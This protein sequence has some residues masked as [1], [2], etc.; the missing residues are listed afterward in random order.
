MKKECIL[1]ING[2]NHLSPDC[3]Q[4]KSQYFNLVIGVQDSKL[5]IEKERQY[6]FLIYRKTI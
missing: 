6:S 2:N 3:G 4:V 5:Y 1:Q